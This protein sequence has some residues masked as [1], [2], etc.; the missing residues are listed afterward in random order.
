MQL[1]WENGKK[2]KLYINY[3]KVS[4]KKLAVYRLLNK[5]LV[6]FENRRVTSRILKVKRC[7][8]F[9]TFYNVKFTTL[10]FFYDSIIFYGKYA[11]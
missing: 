4:A 6:F 1:T 7:K 2:N 8:N 10:H 9:I 5:W 3:I 11:V